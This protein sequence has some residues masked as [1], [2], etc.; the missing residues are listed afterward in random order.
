MLTKREI[1]VLELLSNSFNC[2]ETGKILNLSETTII[3][4]KNKL[5]RKLK[6][7]NL[8]HLIKLALFAGYLSNKQENL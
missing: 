1:E 8:C 3:T 5:K 6:A 7:K 4:H 2:Y